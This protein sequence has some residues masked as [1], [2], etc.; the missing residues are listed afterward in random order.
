VGKPEKVR[1]ASCF[2]EREMAMRNWRKTEEVGFSASFYLVLSFGEA[3]ERT[4][5]I[6]SNYG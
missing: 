4:C 1:T 6:I 5:N 2:S 3:K